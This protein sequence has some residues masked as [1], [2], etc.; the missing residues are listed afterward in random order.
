MK[1]SSSCMKRK[2]GKPKFTGIASVD[3]LL[4]AAQTRPGSKFKAGFKKLLP[5]QRTATIRSLRASYTGVQTE[6][7]GLKKQLHDAAHMLQTQT[8][9]HALLDAKN[10]LLGFQRKITVVITKLTK[11]NANSKSIFLEFNP[12]TLT[13]RPNSVELLA[14]KTSQM[15]LELE[16]EHQ[17]VIK[18]KK[19]IRQSHGKKR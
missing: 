5:K 6:I 12:A 10:S 15:L 2:A 3:A 16:S 18:L 9:G 7:R 17:R 4:K 14:L 1:N 19:T 11:A 13:R 8:R